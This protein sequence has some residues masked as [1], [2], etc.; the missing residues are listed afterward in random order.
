MGTV[1]QVPWTRITDWDAA[2]ADLRAA[3][4]RLAALAL[5][6]DAVSLDAYAKNRPERVALM[7]GS[8]GE[9]LSADAL[10]NADAIVTIPMTGGVDSLNVAA[11]AAVALWAMKP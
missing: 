6:D 9:G 2:V 1:F 11:A 5:R 7:M 10:A 3:D 8:E 4:I